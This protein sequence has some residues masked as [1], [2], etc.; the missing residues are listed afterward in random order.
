MITV[1]PPKVEEKSKPEAP[2]FRDKVPANWVITECEDGIEARSN[3]TGETF[4][5]SIKE[6]SKLLRS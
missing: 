2:G 1:K 4:R 5:G 3:Q 6:F